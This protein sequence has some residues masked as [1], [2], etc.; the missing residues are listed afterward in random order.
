METL[1]SANPEAKN[2]LEAKL[3]K[4]TLAAAKYKLGMLKTLQSMDFNQER[5]DAI[6]W[7]EKM[8]AR[9]TAKD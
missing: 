6:R 9:L 3:N 7:L 5:K 1:H 8:V 2:Y 4:L